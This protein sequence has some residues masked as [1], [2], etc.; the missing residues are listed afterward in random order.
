MNKSPRTALFK[1]KIAIEALKEN[2]TI[3]EIAKEHSLHRVQVS[4]WKKELLD[5]AESIFEG[6]SRKKEKL[7]DNKEVLER[8]IGQLTI[9]IDWLKKKLGT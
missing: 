5:G 9:E 8:K 1:K 4:Q 7:D 2:K 6:K 3:E